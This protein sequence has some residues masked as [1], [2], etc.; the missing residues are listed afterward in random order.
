VADAVAFEFADAVGVGVGVGELL[1]VLPQEPSRA[2][3]TIQR[4]V[5]L[6]R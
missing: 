6:A 4:A 5:M 2:T 3:I 1:S